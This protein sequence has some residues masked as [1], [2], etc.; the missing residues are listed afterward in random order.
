RDE[1]VRGRSAGWQSGLL[2]RSGRGKPALRGFAQPFWADT[3]IARGM[4]RLWGQ[5]RPEGSHAVS[6][7]RR[8]PGSGRWI[9]FRRLRTDRR[10]FFALRVAVTRR[11]DYRFTWRP[12]AGAP[13]RVSDT[14]G[15]TPPPRR[16][17]RR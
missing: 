7:Q 14:R 2:F 6:V 8:A 3:T 9:T 4:A 17:R 11:M 13:L 1:R 16:A 5:V 12:R 15:V 10:G